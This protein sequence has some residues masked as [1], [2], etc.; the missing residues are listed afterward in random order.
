MMRNRL[1]PGG[2]I[3]WYDF[4]YNNPRNPDVRGIGTG[5][6]KALFPQASLDIRRVTLAPP[7]SRTMCK[8]HPCMYPALNWLP[9]LRTHV[10]CWISKPS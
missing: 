1:S 6:I 4:T 10:L 3:L 9:L 5:R 8:I 2:G 7:I